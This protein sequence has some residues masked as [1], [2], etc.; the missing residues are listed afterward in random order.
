MHFKLLSLSVVCLI[1][2]GV[3]AL[4][5]RATN[6]HARY[7][8]L[9]EAA[10]ILKALR[11]ILPGDL[12]NVQEAELPA[13]W[14]KWVEHQD[15][16]IR[17]RL[18]EGDE[19]S[20]VN[21][22]LF[23]TSFTKKTRITLSIL[24]KLG[25]KLA[26]SRT[27]MSPEV[28][29]LLDSIK[30]RADD[31]IEAM[32][33]PNPNERVAFARR[34]L[35][36]KGIDIK[37]SAG[38]QAGKDYLLSSLVRV[39]KKQA[40]YAKILESARLLG[41]PSA[42]FAERSRLFSDRGLSSD[43]SLLPNFAIEKA[44]TSIKSQG[45]MGAGQI[46]RI[47]IIGPGL[48]FTD[49]QDGYDFYPLQTIQPFAIIDTA[50][51][52]GL[53]KATNLKITTLDLSPRINDHVERARSRGATGT[54]YVIQLPRDTQ[55]QWK[56]EA[57]DYWKRFGDQIGVAATPVQSPSGIGELTVRAVRVRPQ[58]AASI[59][60]EDLNVVVQRL[61]LRR[62]DAFDLI[63]ATNIL[64]YYDT[65]EQSLALSNIESMLKPGGFLLSNNALLEL[66]FSGMRSVGY[67]TAV[68]S[69]K[70]NDGDH[71]VWY[72][73]SPVK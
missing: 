58:I 26:Q 10:P 20:V 43:T 67:E 36:S 5:V 29:A 6:P 50:L 21:F 1:L 34:V 72:Q 45:L 40:G 61:D 3:P 9:D 44:L 16:D 65:F 18:A 70:P 24:A 60:P 73:R 55:G 41:D 71:I 48:D 7:I 39:L 52:L 37:T 17:A 11:E 49:K 27:G 53:A 47:G 28:T 4:P 33:A 30:S 8:N 69:D 22:L 62:E 12:R 54:P 66:P 35:E 51:R 13:A 25:E 59:A 57:I 15:Q 2:I 42:E 46:T 38:H 56:P 64:V 14:R 31:L 32:V 19:D 63:I 23:G 68:Y